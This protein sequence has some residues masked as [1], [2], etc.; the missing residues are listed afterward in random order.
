MI[1]LRNRI[2]ATYTKAIFDF[3]HECSTHRIEHFTSRL[4]E[5]VSRRR[6]NFRR[7]VVVVESGH[8]MLLRRGGR[9][10]GLEI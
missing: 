8:Q 4:Q 5:F 7:E 2:G 3:V 9:P 6:R 10:R 1:K